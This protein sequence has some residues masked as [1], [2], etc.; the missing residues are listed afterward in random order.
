MPHPWSLTGLTPQEAL[1]EQGFSLLA[2]SELMTL[3]EVTAASLQAWLPQWDQLPPDDYL[4]DGGI[5]IYDT[6]EVI[7]P[8]EDRFRSYAMPFTDI[9]KNEVELALA[10]NMVRLFDQGAVSVDGTVAG[11]GDAARPGTLVQVGKRRWLR[12]E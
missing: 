4:R 6:A 7:E 8:G 3:A 12:L 2:P 10:K 1:Q 5:L 11:A 9:A